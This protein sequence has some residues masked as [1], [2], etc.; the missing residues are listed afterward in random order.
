M[1]AVACA[2]VHTRQV[3]TRLVRC[4][5]R[6]H[7]G[8][9]PC[10]PRRLQGVTKL[11]DS[12][13]TRVSAIADALPLQPG[14]GDITSNLAQRSQQLSS[15]A[16]GLVPLLADVASG[17]S[18]LASAGLEMINSGLS[19]LLEDLRGQQTNVPELVQALADGPLAGLVERI[20]ATLADVT[21][22]VQVRGRGCVA[23]ACSSPGSM[24]AW[25]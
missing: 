10:S 14:L 13:A 16:D 22:S 9:A 18:R 3:L 2:V 5:C 11:L 17:P 4:C 15:A 1:I 24:R 8:C 7:S 12:Y 20:N 21:G 23:C 6:C 19:V 25:S